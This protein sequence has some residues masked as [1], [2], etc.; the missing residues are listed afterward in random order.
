MILK[1]H[2]K[3]AVVKFAILVILLVTTVFK[4]ALLIVKIAIIKKIY[5]LFVKKNIKL[6]KN[7][8]F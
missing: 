8:V 2:V 1:K 4:L 5:V 6:F 3:I 7:S